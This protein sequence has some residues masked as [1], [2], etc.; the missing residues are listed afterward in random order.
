MGPKSKI[1]TRLSAIK[2]RV[3]NPSSKRPMTDPI[4]PVSPKRR[5]VLSV[6][7]QLHDQ[8]TYCNKCQRDFS[9]SF[10]LRRHLEEIHGA[11]PRLS[12][13]HEGCEETFARGDTLGRHIATQHG[14][15]KKPCPKCGSCIRPDGLVEHLATKSCRSKAVE[16]RTIENVQ[17]EQ[18][19]AGSTPNAASCSGSATSP[20]SGTIQS[21][22]C[23]SEI[24]RSESAAS[25]NG[26]SP[27]SAP[28]GDGVALQDDETSVWLSYYSAFEKRQPMLIPNASSDVRLPTLVDDSPRLLPRYG[29]LDIP[30]VDPVR[31][32]EDLIAE[33][34][35]WQRVVLPGTTG[36][37]AD[38]HA[39]KRP[40]LPEAAANAAWRGTVQAGSARWCRFE[41]QGARRR[42]YA[43]GFG[44]RCALCYESLG[45]DPEAVFQ[46]AKSHLYPN[47]N[48]RFRCTAC[49]VPFVYAR[50][51]RLHQTPLEM[52]HF[53]KEYPDAESYDENDWVAYASQE[54][55]KRFIKGLRCW[56]S[57]QL[58][59]YLASIDQLLAGHEQSKAGRKSKAQV[60][61][62]SGGTTQS[63]KGPNRKHV[64][65]GAQ[66]IWTTGSDVPKSKINHIDV[67]SLVE[68]FGKTSLHDWSSVRKSRI[69]EE[70]QSPQER[71][72]YAASVGDLDKVTSILR[73]GHD[74]VYGIT[75][76]SSKTAVLESCK[77]GHVG[78]ASILLEKY[79]VD[80][81]IDMVRKAC[82]A[83]VDAGHLE[84]V[85]KF[86]KQQK[87]N[88]RGRFDHCLDNRQPK[89]NARRC[90]KHL[91]VT[92]WYIA[93]LEFVFTLDVELIGKILKVQCSHEVKSALS[94]DW[95]D[96]PLVFAA[97]QGN[98]EAVVFLLAAGVPADWC[99]NP[100]WTTALQTAA[101][102]GHCDIVRRLLKARAYVDA[103]D[104]NGD[105]ALLRSLKR[106]HIKV[107]AL[108]LRHGADVNPKPN[109][110]SMLAPYAGDHNSNICEQLLVDAG[111]DT[112]LGN[113]P[114]EVPLI[115]ACRE[116][117]ASA[118]I[119]QLLLKSWAN[120]N[121]QD[122]EGRTALHWACLR[123]SYDNADL[124]L[125][126]GATVDIADDSSMTPLMSVLSQDCSSGRRQGGFGTA[127]RGARC[128]VDDV[129]NDGRG[130]LLRNPVI[131]QY[132]T[133][134]MLMTFRLEDDRMSEHD[135]DD[136]MDQQ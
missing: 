43:M 34:A 27:T 68:M 69:R 78:I 76:Q 118:E 96:S 10:T 62:I 80:G 101:N 126:H 20:E 73:S 8:G 64:R 83:A 91:N 37:E 35:E 128:N 88:L 132:N 136:L 112:S 95:E 29:G 125:K 23:S 53:S 92:T 67:T 25:C 30:M 54:D 129:D 117:D 57:L 104:V 127:T 120:A 90:E 51:L 32:F 130:P 103:S 65:C 22:G 56:E 7:N 115:Y 26:L 66:S 2:D 116:L 59:W 41:P 119:V 1:T 114:T 46:H 99:D 6:E 3:L 123:G 79:R 48:P 94:G 12:C 93:L 106:M 82:R 102:K 100:S 21:T 55:R 77:R 9:R 24:S 60:W 81:C 111:V 84:M 52:T 38:Q 58:S 71:L 105:T 19:P 74:P 134:S 42:F 122:A 63:D 47:Q 45:H 49:E 36:T 39:T 121:M 97:Q 86:L 33:V 109:T 31:S 70:R 131:D 124:L 13:A 98:Y 5:A 61:L 108:L 113:G 16:G 110:K 72:L 40:V 44:S 4:V 85:R 107:T 11:P 28:P 89:A 15:A 18:P 14:S 87:S 50:D 133:S 17:G 135:T 75:L